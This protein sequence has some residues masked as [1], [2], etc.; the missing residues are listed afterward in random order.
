[1]FG[2]NELTKPFRRED[3][4]LLVS[5][6]FHTIQ[7]EGPDAGL[8]AVFV[9]L[10][11]CNL[12]CWFCDTD[13]SNGTWMDAETLFKEIIMLAKSKE[14]K[15]IVLTGGEPLL[16]NV[17]PF[18]NECNSNGISVSIETAGTIWLEGL[19]YWFHPTRC[20]KGN[21][22]VCS[23]KTPKINDQIT[24]LVGAYKYI[25]RDN[26]IDIQDGLPIT[27]TQTKGAP[28]KL[29]RPVLVDEVPIFIQPLDEN[30]AEANIRNMQTAAK[31]CMK[32]GY[33]LSLQMHKIVGL[34]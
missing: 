30:E 15:L 27:S 3:G 20:I 7:G 6:W 13:F 9:R 18:V 32:Y 21:L 17:I 14:C 24:E 10:A 12:A 31:V 33:R 22:V 26:E 28:A 2:T 8:S 23:P 19:N 11:K 34:P 16:Q 4:S 5:E 25:I 1:M 29:F